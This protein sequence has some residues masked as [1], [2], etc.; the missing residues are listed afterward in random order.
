[1]S[2]MIGEWFATDA[3][4]AYVLRVESL[5]GRVP[6][7]PPAK[8]SV[9][10]ILAAFRAGRAPRVFEDRTV[11]PT[12]IVDAADAT[13]QLIERAC[14]PGIYHLVCSGQATWL[15][16]ALE[17]ARLMGIPPRV[18]PVKVAD[19]SLRAKRPQ[20]C[21]LSNA[22]LAGQG[23]TMPTWQ[24]ALARHLTSPGAAGQ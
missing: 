19:V 7:G 14:A 22:K 21:A 6:G 18:E 10:S 5:F 23:V 3:E 2:K 15:E 17:A 24:D 4:R 8:G 9:E 16:F 11:S 20:Y 12:Y 1:M 13:F